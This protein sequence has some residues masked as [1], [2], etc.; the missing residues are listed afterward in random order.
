L[1]QLISQMVQINN[2]Q[3]A[4]INELLIRLEDEGEEPRSSRNLDD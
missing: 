3:N 2:E 1:I 4:Q